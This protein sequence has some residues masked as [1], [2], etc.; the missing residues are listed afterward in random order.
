MTYA[1]Q[2]WTDN[3]T[4]VDAA[5]MN[6]IEDALVAAPGTELDY[7]ESTVDLDCRTITP[8]TIM[9]TKPIAYNGTTRVRLEAMCFMYCDSPGT[10][11]RI[12]VYDESSALVSLIGD[13][14]GAAGGFAVSL[15]GV[16]LVTPPVGSHTYSVGV[17]RNGGS[18]G[19]FVS[20]HSPTSPCWLRLT[21]A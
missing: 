4:P 2:T 21:V 20:P 12:G 17:F 13:L 10:E 16:C 5:H 11:G 6:H 1:R 19:V 14:Y 18:G 8:M 3:V 7:Q 9:T 15:C